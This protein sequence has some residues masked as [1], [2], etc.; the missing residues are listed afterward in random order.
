MRTHRCEK[1]LKAKVSIRYEY[2]WHYTYIIPQF[3]RQVKF[4]RLFRFCEFAGI[5]KN[6]KK[7]L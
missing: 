5:Q 2:N 4:N 3:F 6:S 1:S 7:R